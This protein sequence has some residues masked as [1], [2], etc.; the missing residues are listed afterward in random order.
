MSSPRAPA[1]EPTSHLI[2]SRKGYDPR[3][4]F[5]YFILAGMMVLL[6]AG[7]GYQQLSRLRDHRKAERKQSQRRIVMPG[8]RGNILDREGRPLVE[9]RARFS[10]RLLVDQLGDEIFREQTRIKKNFSA[11][12]ERD[13][14][15]RS[16]LVQ[17]ARVSVVQHYLD[18]VNRILGRDEKVN[19]KVLRDHFSR[20]RLLPFTLLEDL[21]PDEYAKLLERLPVNSAAQLYTFSTRHYPHGS[22][23][24]HTLGFVGVAD[25]IDDED[26]PDED[27]RTFKMKGTIGRGG[28][29]QRFDAQLQGEAGG[30]IFRVDHTGSRI[31]PPLKQVLPR[32]GE[33]VSLSLDID[34]QTA[35]EERLA[36]YE[37]PGAAIAMD[38]ATG[39]VLVLASKPD[40]DLTQFVPRLSTDT[41]QGIESRGAWLNR[42]TQGLYM[43]GSSFKI[44]V[45]IAGLRSGVLTPETTYQCA[46]VYRIG[47]FPFPCHDRHAHGETD[48]ARAI[49]KSCNIFFAQAGIDMTPDR[50]AEEARRFHL[51]R[52]TGIEL[53]AETPYMLIPDPAWKRR[54]ENA[55]WTNGDTA[56]MS[57]GQASV[58][59]T[60][61]QMACF[62]ASVARDE[63]WTQ[64]Y[65]VHEENR[66][67][68]H[69]EKIGLTPEQRAKLLEGMERVT[70]SA[71][72]AH[73]LTDNK[74]LE[75]LPM[76]IAA[77]TGTAQKRTDKGTINFAWLIC[78][79]PIE[80]PQIAI[81]V[82]IEGDTPGE[83]TGGGRYCSPVAHSIMK[84]WLE[85]KNQPKAA[86]LRFRTE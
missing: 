83:E 19:V 55:P 81:A 14:P 23:A 46:G 25:D 40:Y 67:R 3:V 74:G 7:L 54:T 5:F 16:D 10:V 86:P 42:A 78:F 35:A 63:V 12:A 80:N 45:A 69:Q 49:E 43:P 64:P 38:V 47:N 56:N 32:K 66:P 70:H 85:K 29:E 48:L 51:D 20:E 31:N 61:L 82:A 50:I 15:S 71:G 1:A 44:L 26:V 76:R 11:A 65:L 59:V 34:L 27:L 9:N 68:Q 17:L 53:P 21:T 36:E 22:A 60:P 2:E 28:I 13:M 18:E 8:P 79:A 41:F 37:L 77:K 6:A 75:P 33:D 30:A 39:E 73:L 62:I 57:I 52:R 72:T 24:A 58:T 4:T 84:K